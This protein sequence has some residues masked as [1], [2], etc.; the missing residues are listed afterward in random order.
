MAAIGG[1]GAAILPPWMGYSQEEEKEGKPVT[2][3]EDA[4][5]Y[6]RNKDS[7][8]GKY[9]GRVVR[10]THPGAVEEGIINKTVAEKMLEEAVLGLTGAANLKEAWLQFV[11]P[12]DIIGLK[13][14]PVAGKLLTTSHE[15][16]RA[17]IKQLE[18]AGIPRKNLVIW[19]RREMQL[20]EAGY[21]E[22]EYPGIKITGTECQDK[23]GSLYDKEGKLYSESRIDKD[24]YYWADVEGEYDAYT[25]PYMV[26]E[27]KYSYFTKI[28]TREVDKIINLPILKNAG[29]S[30]TLCMK[31]LAYGSIT[32]TGRL[33]KKLWSDTSAEACAFPPLR[34]KVV[35]NIVDGLKGCY[36]GGPSAN[37]QYFHN[38]NSL[39]AGTDPVAVDQVGYEMVTK[40]RI[41]KGVQEKEDP[42]FRKFMVMAEDLQLGIAEPSKIERINLDLG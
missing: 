22:E 4:L 27:G 17:V 7:M 5:K 2:N 10:V 26:N 29:A 3:I 32:N 13:V 8:P 9:P 37:P 23:E 14:N 25:L 34:D 21:T 15:V 11:G 16:C 12:D 33:H 39:L 40:V 1:I 36:D 41:D 20:H 19:D 28:V 38:Y 42:R 6:P 31:N 18:S 30:V 35:L 24:W